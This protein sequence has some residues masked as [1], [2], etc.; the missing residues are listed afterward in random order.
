MIFTEWIGGVDDDWRLNLGRAATSLFRHIFHGHAADVTVMPAKQL[1]GPDIVD[2]LPTGA[3]RFAY[4]PQN[5]A[6]IIR[7]SVK[8]AV[9]TYQAFFPDAGRHSRQSCGIIALVPPAQP[10][11]IVDGQ[12][13]TEGP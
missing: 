3:D 5:K 7:L 9:A 1:P 11:Q 6:G 12:P 8:I 2:G 10:Q 13:T 4:E